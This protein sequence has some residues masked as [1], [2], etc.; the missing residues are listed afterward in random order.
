MTA[1]EILTQVEGKRL[2]LYLHSQHRL[3]SVNIENIW[4]DI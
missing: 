2:G 4:G 1:E 3:P